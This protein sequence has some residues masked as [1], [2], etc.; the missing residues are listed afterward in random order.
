MR[1]DPIHMKKVGVIGVGAMGGALTGVICDT[2][3]PTD[4]VIF[5]TSESR[6]QE[7]A[8]LTGCVTA[9]NA[10]E[11]ARDCE[12]VLLA[13]KPQIVELVMADLLPVMRANADEGK[14]QIFVSIAAGW[15]L[16]RLDKLFADAGLPEMPVTRAMPNIP[17]RVK[18]GLILF[19]SDQNTDD[20]TAGYVRGLFR[21]G[22]MCVQCEEELLVTA[23]AVF[24]CS[25]AMVYMF[26][27]SI[28]DAGVQIGMDRSRATSFAAQAVM[29]SA[30]MVLEGSKHIGQLKEELDTPGG[31]T[32]GGTNLMEQMGFRGAVIAGVV[33]AHERQFGLG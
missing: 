9:A 30:A 4:V 12:V 11:I 26:I 6:A 1:K 18:Q 21:S 3:A 32:I 13:V 33:R 28:A 5:D 2:V 8:G 19:T 10:E 25:P 17:V 20:K 7:I 24:S 16:E 22:G 27:E 23:C 31:M 15:T 29:G 14:K